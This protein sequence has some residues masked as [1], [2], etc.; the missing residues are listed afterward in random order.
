MGHPQTLEGATTV[1]ASVP[2]PGRRE[3]QTR[4][5]GKPATV[6]DSPPAEAPE[7]RGAITQPT[8]DALPTC[9]W[10]AET[11]N[12]TASGPVCGEPATH[13]SCNV[14]GGKKHPSGLNA[15][16]KHKCRCAT[17]KA[18]PPPANPLRE[19]GCLFDGPPCEHGRVHRRAGRF[20]AA[21]RMA[22]AKDGEIVRL[23]EGLAEMIEEAEEQAVTD[24]GHGGEFNLGAAKVWRDVV[25]GLRDLCTQHPK[26]GKDGK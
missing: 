25:E 23:R 19:C 7:S 9:G 14:W 10:F 1:R 2:D 11:D 6:S 17:P 5:A 24:E 15:C 20:V 16:V 13:Y 8:S 3:T 21:H 12:D 26:D 22:D 18:V 4:G